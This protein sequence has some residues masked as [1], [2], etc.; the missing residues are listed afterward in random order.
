VLFAGAAGIYGF[1]KD[2]ASGRGIDSYGTAL[3]WTAMILTTMGSEYWPKTDAGR[4]LCFL[5]ALYAF[6]VFGYVTATLATYF[7]GR[8]AASDES[9]I[10]GQRS[11]D[12]LREEVAQLREDLRGFRSALRS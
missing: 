2:V 6:T 10:A 11:V 9:D 12:A 8:D 1:E 3:W 5:L 4:I 7:V